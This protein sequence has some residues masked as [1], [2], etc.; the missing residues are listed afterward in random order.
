MSWKKKKKEDFAELQEKFPSKP[1]VLRIDFTELILVILKRGRFCKYA[2]IRSSIKP[3][4]QMF[5]LHTPPPITNTPV[6]KIIP[7]SVHSPYH[8]HM[9]NQSDYGIRPMPKGPL[10][11]S[12]IPKWSGIIPCN[13]SD[14][15][16]PISPKRDNPDTILSKGSLRVHNKL[17][18]VCSCVQPSAYT[19]MRRSTPLKDS[20]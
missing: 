14:A 3:I 9:P 18:P 13:C 15:I 5:F 20:P 11:R 16:F 19:K 2:G 6:P 17:E 12:K 4:W 7:N 10:T 8:H 1:C